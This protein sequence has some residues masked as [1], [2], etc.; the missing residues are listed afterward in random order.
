MSDIR[1]VLAPDTSPRRAAII[2]GIGYVVLFVLAIYANFVVREGLVVAGDA[3]ATAANIRGS[4][5]LFRL[6]LV[7][8]LIIFIVDVFVAWA[9]YIVFRVANR[10]VSLLGA[11]LRIVYTVFLG[12]AIIFFYQTLQLLS[13]A[14]FL[15]V[16][17]AAEL[18][19]QAL[20]ALDSFNSTWLVG[21]AA[22]GVHLVVMG[23][24]IITTRLA[25]KVL[26]YV[27]VVSGVAYVVDTIA[28]SM[29]SNYAE[30]ALPFTIMVAVPSILAEGWFGLWL[31]L[32]GGK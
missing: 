17:A 1:P 28:H 21:L 20:V 23:Y 30:Y 19:A 31:L 11:W 32:K 18:E 5:G 4:E 7:C 14:D 8:F 13:G 6:G 24:L 26:G 15:A 12:V 10:D 27:L 9:L 3:A 29:L 16:I 2:A 22:F 25:P